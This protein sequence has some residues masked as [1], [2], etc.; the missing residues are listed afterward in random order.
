M[1]LKLPFP[2]S[3]IA[4]ESELIFGVSIGWSRGFD[5]ELR[6]VS[7]SIIFCEALG[8]DKALVPLIWD[9]FGWLLVR[10]EKFIWTMLYPPLHPFTI[11]ALFLRTRMAGQRGILLFVNAFSKMLPLYQYVRMNR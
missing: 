7:H 1:L 5:L 6:V 3:G 8:R 4:L 10:E 2:Q 9:F 11:A